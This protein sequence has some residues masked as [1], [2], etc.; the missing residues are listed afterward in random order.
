MKP[1]VFRILVVVSTLLT[2]APMVP[3]Q[4]PKSVQKYALLV[5]CSKYP[6]QPEL[7]P[8]KGA[9]NDVLL[10]NDLLIDSA[11]FA[12]PPGVCSSL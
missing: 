3:A 6:H 2:L 9:A 1:A 7:H 4:G 8:L 12:F 11:G 5:G 10:W